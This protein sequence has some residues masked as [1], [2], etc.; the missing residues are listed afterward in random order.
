MSY[1]CKTC[2]RLVEDTEKFGSGRFCSRACANK[3]NH[4][5]ETKENIRRGI[6]K[7]TPCECQFCGKQFMNLTAKASHE[8]LC[9][10]N[11][12]RLA[13]AGAEARKTTAAHSNYKVRNGDI[14]DISNE[15]IEEYLE[16]HQTCEI[17]G[18]TIEESCHW[19]SKFKPKRL[20]VDHDHKTLKFRGVLCSQCNRQLG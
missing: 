11:P 18:K 6:L 10:K 2:G 12:N 5:E 17:C 8:R 16:E 20:C 1:I 3:R 13:N 4:S 7:E 15:F 19:D 14:L 9:I